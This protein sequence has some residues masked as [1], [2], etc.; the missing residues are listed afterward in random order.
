MSAKTAVKS[1]LLDISKYSPFLR[2]LHLQYVIAR[3]KLRWMR[4]ARRPIDEKTV[5]FQAYDGKYACSPKAVYEYMIQDEQYQDYEFVWAVR[6]PKQYAGLRSNPRT[7]VIA[8]KS[9]EYYATFATAKYWVVNCMLPLRIIK[10]PGQVMVQCWHGT[11]LKR[12]R[13]DIIENTRNAMN[14][15]A[16]FIRKNTI[17]AA[18]YDYMLS[19][20]PFVTEKFITAFGAHELYRSGRILELG[21]PRNDVLKTVDPSLVQDIK[22]RLKIPASKTVLLYAPTWRDDQHDSRIGYT[23]KNELDFARLRA[24][25]GKNFVVLFRAHYMIASSFNFAKFKGFVYDVSDIDD[26][27]DLYLISDALITDYSSVMFDYAYLKR[28][29]LY[30]MYDRDYY[31]NE[32]RG[33]Y[34]DLNDLPGELFDDQEQLASA[35]HNLPRYWRQHRRAY[36]AFVKRFVWH[37][38]GKA[39]ARLAAKIF[40]PSPPLAQTNPARQYQLTHE[41]TK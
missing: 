27:N 17:D 35:L 12:L 1:V 10:R 11:P 5:V 13:N 20:S 39:S 37:N 9:R 25:L 21:Y 33:F 7:T 28:P 26:V 18:R 31:E 8:T 32:L 24:A 4:Y 34:M 40:K 22:K 38:D 19:P 23:Y 6:D 3:N 16:D 15:R 29:I 41:G 36:E 30:Y 2:R 14:S